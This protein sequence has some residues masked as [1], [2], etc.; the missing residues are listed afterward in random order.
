MVT[1]RQ[2]LILGAGACVSACGGGSG[3]PGIAVNSTVSSPPNRAVPGAGPASQGVYGTRIAEWTQGASSGGASI[4]AD[5]S[6][7]APSA[8]VLRLGQGT[9]AT[10][11]QQ[12][13]LPEA[14][15]VVPAG[16]SPGFSVGVWA[17]NPQARTL[18]FT[19]SILNAQGN[20]EI[21]WNCAV[22]PSTDWVFLT[23]SPSQ[24]LAMGWQFGVDAP[25]VVR[26]AQQDAMSEGSWQAGDYLLFGAVFVDL[27]NRPLFFLTFD[28]G[29]ATQCHAPTSSV[30]SG[31]QVVEQYGFKGTLFIVPSWLGTSGKFGYG[32]RSN[33]FMSA[34]DVLAMRAQG[35]SVGS[36]TNTHPSSRD[37]AGLRLLGPYGYFLSNP[38][39]HLPTSY[40]RTWGLDASHRRRAS[41]A[42]AGSPVIQFEN[43]HRFL[44]N[45][46]IVFTDQAPP[47]FAVG[48]VYYCQSI[49][50]DTSATFATDQ[51]SLKNTVTA[52]AGWSGL[53]N[54]RYPGSASDDSAI[55]ADIIA[56]AD[57]L[58]RLGISTGTDYFALPQGSADQYVRSACLRA[59]IRWIRGASDHGHSFSVG[60]PTGGGLSNIL[61][62]PGGWLAQ[63]DCIQ[64][65][66]LPAPT[67]DQ[68]K[69]Y[70]DATVVQGACGCSYH[71]NVVSD[72]VG[73]LDALCAYLK[74]KVDANQID[75][76]TLDEF[77]R[78]RRPGA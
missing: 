4:V 64:T 22:D 76:I 2:V 40:V 43:P 21:R 57:G 42:T 75:V 35:W 11:L 16:T 73:N 53:A 30:L 69:Q 39:D 59:G 56:G 41:G 70:A 49:P 6:G 63:P 27:G 24:Q 5:T 26:I 20:H 62:Q 7:S 78:Y 77:A 60:R 74:T 3:A 66:G 50:S 48:T 32:M 25:A 13:V 44:V 58:A 12:A 46:P 37:N 10:V 71:H 67:L 52:G 65:D 14:W 54:Y 45:L 31:R 23:M 61:D 1:R 33:T 38:V 68:I 34:D 17:R 28:D 51:G 36:H 55:Y 72:T 18:N 29:F 15:D 9:P 8:S 47:G 19:F